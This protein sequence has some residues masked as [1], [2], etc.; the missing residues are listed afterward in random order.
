MII[1]H[2][3]TL[4][5][6][7]YLSTPENTTMRIG[8]GTTKKHTHS[9]KKCLQAPIWPNRALKQPPYW[10]SRLFNVWLKTDPS[11]SHFSPHIRVKLGVSLPPGARGP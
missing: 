3:L 9:G 1:I 4:S 2:F 8:S 11:P 5:I 6:S 7:L 10:E